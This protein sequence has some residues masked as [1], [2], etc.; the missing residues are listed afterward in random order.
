VIGFVAVIG[1]VVGAVTSEIYGDRI[2]QL[3]RKR[4]REPAG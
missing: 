2:D 4:M 1:A 3:A